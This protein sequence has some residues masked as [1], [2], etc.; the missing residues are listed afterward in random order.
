MDKKTVLALAEANAIKK[1]QIVG[2]GSL[3]YVSIKTQTGEH[4]IETNNGKLKTWA[5]MDSCAKW[6]HGLGFG[7]VQMDI[8]KWHPHQRGMDII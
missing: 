6:L 3:L 4:N 5:T 7:K 8:A 1:I 2:N